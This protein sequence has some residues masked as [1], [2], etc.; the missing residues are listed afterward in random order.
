[1]IDVDASRLALVELRQARRHNHRDAVHWI[2]ALYRV[3]ISGL[4]AVIAVVVGAGLFG[5]GK[6]SPAEQQSFV[7]AAIPW[8]GLGFAFAVSIGMRSGGRGGPL[9]LEAAT[10]QH[11]LQ[12]PIPYEITLREPALKQ[13]RFLAFTG[14]SVGGIVGVLAVRRFPE[15]P[16]EIVLA[17]A[18]AFALAGVLAISTA[19]IFSGRRI[20]RPISN[21][22]A[23]VLLLWSVADIVFKT[24]TSP[25]T[26]LGALA[27]AGVV[28]NPLSLITIALTVVAA[29][30][31]IA[32]LGG[33]SIDDARRRA[34][35]V[36]Q[37]RFAV[38]LQDIR[39]VVLLRRQLAQETPRARPWIPMKRG[40]RTP[41]VWR[42]DWRSYFRYPIS[43]LAR[44]VLLAV[45]A[46]VCLGLTW[47][48][49]KPAFLLSAI[50]LYLA[51]YDAVEPLAQEIDHPSRW[52][53]LPEDHGKLLLT[54][55][56]AAFVVMLFV[57]LLTA[58]SALILTPSSVVLALLPV[59]IAPVA[60]AAMAGA[61]LSTVMGSPDVAK[62][63]GG[64][65]ADVMGFVLM[66]RLV[67]PPALTVAALAA[68]FAAGGNADALDT[69]RVSNLVG[70]S[71]FVSAGALIYIRYQK[72][73][74]I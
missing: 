30:A 38:T 73:A 12:A 58:A 20:S 45:V 29:V 16:V 56:P 1:V 44:M 62:M 43:R 6:L 17:C 8:L 53:D 57:C 52:D 54:H 51:G 24:T 15:N 46:G 67:F 63:L 33:T 66:A 70:Y 37:L 18:A 50:A 25:M 61:A 14:M 69:A 32:S 60:A 7:D 59:M 9:T 26:L 10:V 22:L 74:R 49:I 40:G 27:C 13:M 71:L 47:R 4:V 3:Y 31:A 41:A 23:V 21:V 2:D 35:L 34:G 72:P 5:D 65:G 48:G 36:S 39:T 19:M 55:L 28:F 11:E 64:L 68:M 42:R